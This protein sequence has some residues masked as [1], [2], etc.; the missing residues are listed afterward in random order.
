MNGRGTGH[1]LLNAHSIVTF[2]P[3]GRVTRQFH[4]RA[5]R[6]RN[7]IFIRLAASPKAKAPTYLLDTRSGEIYEASQL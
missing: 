2:D 1:L 7:N 5:P 6:D 3:S 4:F